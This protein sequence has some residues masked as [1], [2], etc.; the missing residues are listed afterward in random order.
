M[1]N[2][3]KYDQ[4]YVY[5]IGNEGIDDYRRDRLRSPGIAMLRMES[6]MSSTLDVQRVV[7]SAFA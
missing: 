5:N 4:R 3:L 7:M 1:G 2:D 6:W